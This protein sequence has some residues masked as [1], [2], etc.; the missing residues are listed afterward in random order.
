MFRAIHTRNG[1]A[2]LNLRLHVPNLVHWRLYTQRITFCRSRTDIRRNTMI[3]RNKDRERMVISR[4]RLFHL[5]T[6]VRDSYNCQVYEVLAT[7]VLATK[8]IQKVYS[9]WKK[10]YC[11]SYSTWEL[12]EEYDFLKD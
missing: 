10:K 4:S 12:I 8:R 1:Q 11:Y 5:W 3:R 7:K 2:H 6:T 9:L